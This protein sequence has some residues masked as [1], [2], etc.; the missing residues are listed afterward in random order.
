MHS[1]G[2]PSPGRLSVMASYAQS[3]TLQIGG[4]CWFIMWLYTPCSAFSHTDTFSCCT[5]NYI[6]Q[7]YISIYFFSGISF[8]FYVLV[9]SWMFEPDNEFQSEAALLFC[10]QTEI[11]PEHL[12]YKSL[13]TLSSQIFFACRLVSR[14]ILICGALI[15]DKLCLYKQMGLQQP[16]SEFNI[17]FQTQAHPI[18]G[19]VLKPLSASVIVKTFLPAIMSSTMI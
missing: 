1:S 11:Q 16:C 19:V 14:Y 4:Q 6:I 9:Y 7:K 8:C 17:P 5:P 2:C 13:W 12:L 15:K 18:V 10:V 3:A